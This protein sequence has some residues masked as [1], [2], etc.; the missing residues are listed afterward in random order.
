MTMMVPNSGG[1]EK[2]NERQADRKQ[3][4]RI[5][6]GKDQSEFQVGT[7]NGQQAG[8]TGG[9]GTV[10]YCPVRLVQEMELGKEPSTTRVQHCAAS[11]LCASRRLQH[12]RMHIV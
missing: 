8:G 10:R 1:K 12:R 4:R 5:G 2:W 11:A 7:M 6:K 9:A 3:R